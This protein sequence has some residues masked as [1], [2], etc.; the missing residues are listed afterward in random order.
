MK[1]AIA[2][3]VMSLVLAASSMLYPGVRW[4]LFW[5]ALSFGMVAL[6]YAGIG[7][8]VFGKGRD[9]RISLPLKLLNLPYLT[10]TWAIW[11]LCR[12][13]SREA[14]FNQI[15]DDL[16]IG[17]RLLASEAPE[18]FD[19]YVDLTAEFEEPRPIRARPG[20]CC[21]P[22]LDA[23]V[24][25]LAELRG[26]VEQAAAGRAFV[27]CAQGHG[28]TGL[29]ALALLLHH[30]RVETIEEGI[31]LLQNLRPAVKLNRIQ[32]EFAHRYLGSSSPHNL[33]N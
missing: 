19:H 3:G 1:Y 22:I 12:L 7:P 31:G 25:S 32:V 33:S 9:G 18:G 21:L 11:H 14:S 27:H 28:R 6:G 4:L 15:D 2:F 20:Y 24:P 23:G 16:V 8:R 5:S 13:L 26:A 10:Y 17:R 29:F 30:K